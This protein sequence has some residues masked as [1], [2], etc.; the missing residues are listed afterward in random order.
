MAKVLERL[1]A[2]KL[3]K[4]GCSVGEI[5]KKLHVSK[6]A[7]S[8]WCRDVVLSKKQHDT[9]KKRKIDGG[10]KGRMIGAQMN[11][12]KK[13]ARIEY[14]ARA[15]RELFGY[16][17]EREMLIAGATLYWGEGS[18]KT[19]LG[20][21][22]SDKDM[23]IFM[24]QWFQS[25]AGVKK[26]DFIPRVFINA[27]HRKRDEAIRQYWASLLGLPVSQFRKTAFIKRPNTKKY[28]NHNNYF[29]MLSLRVR[30][31]TDLKYRILGLIEGLKYSNF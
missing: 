5:A 6:S 10:H 14:H 9:L 29:G 26:E 31:S 22:N 18:K 8:L 28:A 17:S 3:R 2:E 21:I 16:L 15:G 19:H 11:H 27:L 1:Q 25:T 20:F 7:A 13:I 30:N 12:Q 24:Y 23:V 4:R